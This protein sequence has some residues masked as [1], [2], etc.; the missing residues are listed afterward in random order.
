MRSLNVEIEQEYLQSLFYVVK[1]AWAQLNKMKTTVQDEKTQ[2]MAR[3]W[4]KVVM[5]I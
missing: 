5:Y 4:G 3:V 1:T 2:A